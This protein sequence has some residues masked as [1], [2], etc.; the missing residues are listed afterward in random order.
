[1]L[2]PLG[3]QG[4][5]SIPKEKIL[6]VR[7]SRGISDAVDTV[8]VMHKT[9]YKS[10]LSFKSYERGREKWQGE[11]LDMVW[12]DEEPPEDIYSEGLARIS[13]KRGMVFMT[14]TPLMGM[15]D[16]V[17][18][19]Y[20]DESPDRARVQMS[21]DDAE[22][23]SPEDRASIIAGYPE[24]EREARVRGTPM[25][26]SGLIFPVAESVMRIPA[27]I[28]PPHWV[29][30]VGMDF[31]YQNFA[32]VWLAWDRDSDTVYVTDIYT[33][34]SGTPVIHAAA[35][36]A[37]GPLPCAWPHDGISHDKGS[38][39]GLTAQYKA[40]GL[41]M[42]ADHATFPD[43]SNGVEAGLMDMLDRMQTGRFKVFDHL[44]QW[45]EEYRTYHRKDGKVVKLFD[46]LLDAT[47]YGIMML[48]HA[49]IGGNRKKR[50]STMALG[51]DPN[52]WGE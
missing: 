41:A 6:E 2:G 24:H 31:G 43:G 44:A 28:L 16:V 50:T 47:R 23:I 49:R 10:Q 32:A 26:G 8:I 52:A 20:Q 18:R 38:G 9:G 1:M 3:Q 22:H 27:M 19:F 36:K 13:A 40:Q 48:R 51:V 14:F 45:W 15:S 35:I 30:I 42:I 7:S 21:I 4:T 33:S 29:R 39:V 46:H 5:G 11:T 37:R 34:K 12:F 17:R 25:M